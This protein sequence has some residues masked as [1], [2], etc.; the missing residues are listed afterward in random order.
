MSEALVEHIMYY[1]N[2][3]R[4]RHVNINEDDVRRL[5]PQQARNIVGEFADLGVVYAFTLDMTESN[6]AS[7]SA[8]IIKPIGTIQNG[9]FTISPS[10]S[11]TLSRQNIR[12]FTVIDN[13]ETLR[14]LDREEKNKKRKCHQNVGPNFE[15]PITGSI[16]L[17]E[18]LRTFISLTFKE[19]LS[20]N[21]EDKLDYLGK[22]GAPAMAD[23]VKFTTTV[24]AGA[25]PKVTLNQVSNNFQVASASSGL[26][27][28]RIDIHQ[29]IIGLGLPTPVQ[30]GKAVVLD[31]TLLAR[32]SFVTAAAPAGRAGGGV[33]NALS[34]VNQQILRFELSRPVF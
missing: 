17:A 34:A 24:S 28:S 33:A 9:L 25:P 27:A 19:N 23:T 6:I 2:N 16:G 31:R 4:R 22:V 26:S 3:D 18:E 12:T 29:V 13:F 14:T 20:R 15:Y 7:I 10:F 5:S 11:N 1:H 32:P 8:D 21:D 30:R